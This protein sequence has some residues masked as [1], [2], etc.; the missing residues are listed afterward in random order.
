MERTTMP[1]DRS[2]QPLE[3]SC[4][5]DQNLEEQLFT[6]PG[7]TGRITSG[8]RT[9]STIYAFFDVRAWLTARRRAFMFAN[10]V[11]CVYEEIPL[12]PYITNVVD[13]NSSMDHKLGTRCDKEPVS[14]THLTLPTI[15]SV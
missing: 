12:D 7:D 13:T 4:R 2:N 6:L 11:V 5:E 10:N 15:Y 8:F 3:A 1:G 14:Y 9:G